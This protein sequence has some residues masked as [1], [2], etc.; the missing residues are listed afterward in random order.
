MGTQFLS[1]K[2]TM[3]LVRVLRDGQPTAAICRRDPVHGHCR[4]GVWRGPPQVVAALDPETRDWVLGLRNHAGGPCCD[5]ADGF[6]VE[7]DG[8]DMAGIV[9]D[10]SGMAPLEASNARS[11]YRVR[12]RDGKWQKE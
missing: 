8:W 7:V 11:C 9:D 12:L 10:T 2:C 3:A 4:S 5:T 1:I 6:P